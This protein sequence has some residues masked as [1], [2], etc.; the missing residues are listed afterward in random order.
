MPR[1]L[2]NGAALLLERRAHAAYRWYRRPGALARA[3][4]QALAVHSMAALA[5]AADFTWRIHLQLLVGMRN[6][7]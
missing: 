1:A 7:L 2:L 5:V 4:N 3:A 6:W